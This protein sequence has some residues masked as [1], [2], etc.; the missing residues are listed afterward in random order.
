M[1]GMGTKLE[2]ETILVSAQ[3]QML[4]RELS[5]TSYEGESCVFRS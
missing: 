3:V 5:E 4:A 2:T 1:F